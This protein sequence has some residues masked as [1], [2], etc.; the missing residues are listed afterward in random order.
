MINQST[1]VFLLVS[2]EKCE[3][4][5]ILHDLLKKVLL[6]LSQPIETVERYLLTSVLDQ[7]SGRR[8]AKD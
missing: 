6:K 2:Y 8:T 4:S 7:L 5:L 1:E 3:I